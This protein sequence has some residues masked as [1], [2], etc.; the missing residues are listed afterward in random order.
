ML[1]G[2]VIGAGDRG[3]GAYAPLLLHE[4][5]LGRIVGV[6]EPNTA[7]REAFAHRYALRPE[8][9]FASDHDLFAAPRAADF[10]IVAT[11]DDHH[12]TP[13]LTALEQGYHVLLE[14]PMATSAQDCR[15]LVDTAERS[16]RILQICHVLR[17]APF[18]RALA[19]V[20][21]GG[22]IGD[23]VTIQHAENVSFWHYAHSY[24]RGRWRNVADS[25]PMILAKSCHDLDL[26]YWL[27]GAEPSDLYSVS[28]PTE[29]CEANAPEGA[30]LQCIEGCPHAARCP[31]DAVALYLDQAPLLRDVAQTRHPRWLGWA[32]RAALVARPLLE[33]LPVR[34]LRRGARWGQWPTNTISDDT[35]EAGLRRA[36]SEGR[37]GRCVYRVG[38]NDQV[39]SQSVGVR[40]RN[41]VNAH[42]S[43]HSTSHREGRTIRIDGT[44]GSIVGAFHSFEQSF[45]VF[46]HASGRRRRQRFRAFGSGHGGGDHALFRGF[47]EAIAG[48]SEPETSARESMTSHLM[49]FAADAAARGLG[50]VRLDEAP[51]DPRGSGTS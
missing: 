40:F 23:V 38:D 48:R 45:D 30:P 22:E 44:R 9:T 8:Q 6:A 31:Y 4:P 33:R 7:R 35:S 24:C 16:G 50:E 5:S 51:P 27:A 20:V 46:D 14:K 18:F 34:A 25:S 39:S 43:M 26:L 1:E 12:V 47:L 11:A 49:A 13:A 3:A 42:F 10:A 2:I 17:Y 36:L 29:L 32:L 37:Y 21:H 19:E 28:R 41:G 15:L